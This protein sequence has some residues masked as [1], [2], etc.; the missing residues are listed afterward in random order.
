VLEDDEMLEH[1]RGHFTRR[2]W[3]PPS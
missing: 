1:M 3:P 2:E